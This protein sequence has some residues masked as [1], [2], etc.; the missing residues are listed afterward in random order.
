MGEGR[1]V[2][3]RQAGLIEPADGKARATMGN[4]RGFL[5]RVLVAVSIAYA[6]ISVAPVAWAQT[7]PTRPV[8]IIVPTTAGATTD[9]IARLIAQALGE[10]LGQQFII[11]NR[12]GGGNTL[13]TEAVVRSAPD[14]YTLL[15]INAVNAINVTLFPKL[16]YDFSADI[17]PVAGIIRVPLVMQVYPGLPAK[18]VPEF[19][20]YARAN[21]GKINMG[22]AGTG[23]TPHVAGELFKMMAGVDL[24]HVPYRGGA[25]A[26]TDLMSGQVQV[27]FEPVAGPLEHLRSGRLRALAV[28]TTARSPALPDVPTVGEFVPGYEASSWY[29]LAAPKGTPAEIVAILNSAV[30]AGLADPKLRM[31]FADQGATVFACSPEDFGRFVA[32]ETDKWGKVVKFAGLRPD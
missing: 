2:L 21:P 1:Q 28:T 27:M 8:R 15:L 23:S 7:W 32:A 4:R 16:N 30:N 24:L 19:L 20:A 17:V 18:T 31:Q 6:G 13:G 10:R 22:S 5:Q 14:G 25:A 11:E 12:P 3:R 29:G 26:M 9:I